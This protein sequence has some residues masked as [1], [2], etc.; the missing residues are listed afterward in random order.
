MFYGVF[1]FS[2][3]SQT[4]C[5]SRKTEIPVETSDPGHLLGC[6]NINLRLCLGCVIAGRW[7]IA[8]PEYSLILV[9]NP[10]SQPSGGWQV[11]S[12]PTC[13]SC[14]SSHQWVQQGRKH[15]DGSII[16]GKKKKSS[17]QLSVNEQNILAEHP[18]TGDAVAMTSHRQ[19]PA[20]IGLS[21]T[22]LKAHSGLAL[23]LSNK[24][25][26]QIYFHTFGSPLCILTQDWLIRVFQPSKKLR[27]LETK[28]EKCSDEKRKSRRT[29]KTHAIAL[30]SLPSV[31]KV[32]QTSALV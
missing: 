10:H 16:S 17:L 20:A 6:R 5:K 32:P 25:I 18:F 8:G 13:P 24:W 19:G 29:L 30:V 22:E 9:G 1:L 21:V 11:F 31:M 15:W 3:V 26:H 4:D 12:I 2:F 23:G 14:L 27:Y 7:N 28:L